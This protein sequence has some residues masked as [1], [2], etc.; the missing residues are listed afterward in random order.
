MLRTQI[1]KLSKFFM[2]KNTVTSLGRWEHRI[3]DKHKEMKILWANA[4]HCGDVI[5]GKPVNIAKNIEYIKKKD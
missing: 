4:D 3:S 5:C 2:P 1:I